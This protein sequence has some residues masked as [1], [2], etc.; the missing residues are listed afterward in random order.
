[1]MFTSHFALFAAKVEKL[2]IAAKLLYLQ[3]K[4]KK[5]QKTK[6]GKENQPSNAL[7]N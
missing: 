1:M 3:Q 2:K 5:K 4:K 6:E 7:K